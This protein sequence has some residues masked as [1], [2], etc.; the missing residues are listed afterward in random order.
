MRTGDGALHAEKLRV[1]RAQAHRAGHALDCR[2]RLAEVELYKSAEEPCPGQVRAESERLLDKGVAIV[3]AV[4]GLREGEACGSQR[5]CVIL[6][7]RDR[8]PSQAPGLSGLLGAIRHPAA[9]C[10][11]YVAPRCHAVS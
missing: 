9:G 1:L 4:G 2:V 6:A 5:D 11:L 7:Q 3:E 8:S 10:P